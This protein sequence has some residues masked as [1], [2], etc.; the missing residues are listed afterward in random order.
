MLTLGAEIA[1]YVVDGYTRQVYAADVPGL[2]SGVPL[3]NNKV[4]CH[5]INP[6]DVFQGFFLPSFNFRESNMDP[7]AFGRQPWYQWVARGPAKDAQEVVLSDG[8]KGWTKYENQ[9][10]ANPMDFSYDLIIAARRKNELNLMKMYAFRHFIPPCPIFKVVDSLGEVR[11][12]DAVEMSYSDTSELADIADRMI[13][14]TI[15]FTVRGEIDLYDERVYPAM[16]AANVTY[17]KFDPGEIN[18]EEP[19]GE[20][21]ET[22]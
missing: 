18:P 13:S 2:D 19:L 15:S 22:A 7:S 3:L 8:R 1:N 5:F 20:A 16:L 17:H 11:Q 12:Y 10:R 6:E 4:P 14:C 21:A 9:F